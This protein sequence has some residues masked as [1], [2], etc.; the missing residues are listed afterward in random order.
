MALLTD[1]VDVASIWCHSCAMADEASV[2]PSDRRRRLSV[3]LPPETEAVTRAI[4]DRHFRGVATDAI[5]AGL[6]LLAWTIDAKRAGKRVVAVEED[7]IPARFEEPV[8]PGL[9]EQLAPRARWL[10]ERKHP[11]RRQPWIK[12]RRMT[13]GDLSRSAEIEG[14][15]AEEA[16]AQFDL[17]VEAVLEAISYSNANRDLVLAEE[18]EN[19][20]A[21]REATAVVA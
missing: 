16:A 9:E 17:P 5:R 19:A 1:V 10:V 2:K 18:R 12:G 4:A 20:L 8:L 6:S 21:A 15:S 7:D 14:W 13:A 3:D 11:W